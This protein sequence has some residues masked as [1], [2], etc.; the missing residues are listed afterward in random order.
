M[1]SAP[2]NF[3][4]LENLMLQ[5]HQ[6][7]R[8]SQ[9]EQ[10]RLHFQKRLSLS[11]AQIGQLKDQQKNAFRSALWGF[12]VNV[13]SQAAAFIPKFGGLVSGFVRE[14]GNLLNPFGR[15]AQQNN[16]KAQELDLAATQEDHQQNLSEEHLKKLSEHRQE[17]N[18]NLKQTRSDLQA[19]QAAAVQV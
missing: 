18:H 4:Q 16:I 9:S 12:F 17:I 7:S 6:Q 19:A 1:Q 10:R 13:L 8:S 2:I 15:K 11:E 3:A 14:L 5:D